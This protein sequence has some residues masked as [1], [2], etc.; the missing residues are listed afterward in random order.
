MLA[1]RVHQQAMLFQQVRPSCP[2]GRQMLCGLVDVE[3]GCVRMRPGGAAA[4]ARAGGSASASVVQGSEVRTQ[5]LRSLFGD[6]Q[7]GHSSGVPAPT[8]G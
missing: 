5:R 7:Y 1:S 3:A 4:N 2:I 8:C 6:S